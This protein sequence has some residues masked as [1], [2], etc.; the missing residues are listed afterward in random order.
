MCVFF[1]FFIVSDSCTPVHVTWSGSLYNNKTLMCKARVVGLDWFIHSHAF[2]VVICVLLNLWVVCI[3]P[4]PLLYL[5]LCVKTGYL[6]WWCYFWVSVGGWEPV[7]CCTVWGDQM[8]HHSA[9]AMDWSF[10]YV[11]RQTPET[12][13]LFISFE[14]IFLQQTMFFQ[15]RIADRWRSVNRYQTT[16]ALGERKGFKWLLQWV[17]FIFNIIHSFSCTCFC[18]VGKGI[19]KVHV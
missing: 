8:K 2:S 11:A 4:Y 6:C 5:W 14:I 16:G 10:Q 9:T 7:A 18:C 19:F 13:I 17:L 12:R 1:F 3:W 15:M